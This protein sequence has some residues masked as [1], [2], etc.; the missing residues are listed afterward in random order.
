MT[1]IL[2][3]IDN[4]YPYLT[5]NEKKIA[6]Y[7]QNAPHEVIKMNS[8]DLAQELDTNPSSIIRFSKKLVDGGFQ[9][10]KIELSKYMPKE[11]TVYNVEL[12][13]NESTSS[14][15]KKML[16]R[17]NGALTKANSNLND[18]TV[19]LIC[20][21]FKHSNRIFIYGYGA[22][23][24][25][26]TDLY[27]KLSRIGMN[28]QLAQETHI[29]TTMLASCDSRDCVVFITNNGTQ[30]EMQS[31]AKVVEDYH[32][33]IV[34][35]TSSPNNTISQMSDIVLDYGETDENEMRM[36]ATT[37]LLAQ[38]FTIDVLYYRYI[39]LNYQSSLDFITQSKMALDNYRKHLSN[40][41]FK[42]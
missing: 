17:A 25:V 13:D 37:S 12:V 9:E 10:L 18:K 21:Q 2:Y 39:A 15:K 40:I 29:F 35:I 1:N 11:T 8:Q 28:A 26:A 30:S 3:E 38:M 32:I 34:T 4:Q 31:I 7:I 42:H 16:A 33:P 36:G 20:D 27:Q 5:K 24:V 22:S 6:N 14:L 41:D 19:D 23:F